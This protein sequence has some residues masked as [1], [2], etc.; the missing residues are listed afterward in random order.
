MTYDGH[1][2]TAAR[3]AAKLDD[4]IYFNIATQGLQTRIL[5]T[6]TS[7]LI[8][9]IE[10]LEAAWK[11]VSSRRKEKEE[12]LSDTWESWNRPTSIPNIEV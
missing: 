7:D 4:A 9:A 5:I 3:M 1:W 12:T 8:L 10:H 11:M 6:E 2:E